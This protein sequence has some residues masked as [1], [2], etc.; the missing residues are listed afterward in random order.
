MTHGSGGGGGMSRSLGSGVRTGHGHMVDHMVRGHGGG[1]GWGWPWGDAVAIN[2]GEKPCPPGF[3]PNT[4]GRCVS[5][6]G[7]RHTPNPAT[8]S[9]AGWVDRILTWP[10]VKSLGV[11]GPATGRRGRHGAAR[12]RGAMPPSK[13]RRLKKNAQTGYKLAQKIAAARNHRSM[14]QICPRMFDVVVRRRSSNTCRW[15]RELEG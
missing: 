4:K 8:R 3:R 7:N 15:T 10:G 5:G 9:G 11:P 6:R 12:T 13:V 14:D 1:G 2:S